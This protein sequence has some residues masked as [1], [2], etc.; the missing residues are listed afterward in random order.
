MKP[1]DKQ[2]PIAHLRMD[3]DGATVFH[4]LESH[5]KETAQRAAE[6]A[7]PFGGKDWA[8]LAGLWH[9]LGS[10]DTGRNIQL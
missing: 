5:L 9:D 1:D 3:E 4:T 10:K 2:Q 8:Y 7:E 6:F